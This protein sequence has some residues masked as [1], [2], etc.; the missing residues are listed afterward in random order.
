MMQAAADGKLEAMVYSFPW[1]FCIDSG[2]AITS[3]EVN[4]PATLR[5]KAKELYDR[6]A[7]VAQPRGLRLRPMVINF[8]DGM[9]TTLA[10]PDLKARSPGLAG[11]DRL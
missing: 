5:W 8:P 2:R 3:S 4:W 7:E 10:L 1:R 11:N 6:F 9:P